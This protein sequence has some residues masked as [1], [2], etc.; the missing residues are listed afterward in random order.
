MLSSVTSTGRGRQ[1]GQGLGDAALEAAVSHC[2]AEPWSGGWLGLR[3]G[4]WRASDTKAGW[5][6]LSK[7]GQHLFLQELPQ[8]ITASVF[9][10][11]QLGWCK[12]KL[13]IT[14]KLGWVFF[15]TGGML[16]LWN[17]SLSKQ[18]K[19][20]GIGIPAAGRLP[21]PKTLSNSVTGEPKHLC[22]S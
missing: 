3:T 9:S 8:T 12:T 5:W 22:S 14:W 1:Q 7:R 15:K 2:K 4:T 11:V 21:Y 17:Y 18:P 16:R 6:P 10:H 20:N 19:L 13:G